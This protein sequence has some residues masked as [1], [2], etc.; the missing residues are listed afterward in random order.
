MKIPGKFLAAG[1]ALVAYVAF[2][3]KRADAA[4]TASHPGATLG[5]RTVR[6]LR[7]N[8]SRWGSKLLGKSSTSIGNSGCLLTALTMA[9]NTFFG[10]EMTPDQANLLVTPNGGFSGSTANLIPE[11]AAR[12]L[13]L[14]ALES[15]RIR[16]EAKA[17]IATLRAKIDDTLMRGGLAIVHVDKGVFTGTGEHFLLVHSKTATGYVGADPAPGVD[18][19]LGLDLRGTAMWGSTPTPYVVVGV[20]PVFAA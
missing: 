9:R 19:A 14:R 13:G 16:Y 10:G 6:I 7:Q 1:V 12:V 17:S 11:T 5:G 15:E 2:G 18:V 8:D 3:S 4:K 20:M